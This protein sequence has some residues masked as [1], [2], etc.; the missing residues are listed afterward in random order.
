MALSDLAS[1]STLIERAILNMAKN[2]HIE[3]VTI[4]TV[5]VRIIPMSANNPWANS[6]GLAISWTVNSRTSRAITCVR[7]VIIEEAEVAIKNPKSVIFGYCKMLIQEI[8]LH[9]NGWSYEELD[10]IRK[11]HSKT[12]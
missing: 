10:E 2:R 11:Y 4:N 9:R 7:R 1:C 5:S 6:L 12:H 3:C 8:E